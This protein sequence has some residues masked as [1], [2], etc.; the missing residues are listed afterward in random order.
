[1]KYLTSGIN[2]TIVNSTKSQKNYSLIFISDLAFYESMK[3]TKI[4]LDK[5]PGKYSEIKKFLRTTEITF[6]EFSRNPIFESIDAFSII[7]SYSKAIERLLHTQ[8]TIPF[9]EKIN[10]SYNGYIPPNIWNRSDRTLKNTFLA[11][12]TS[13]YRVITLG[14]W[15][16]LL[17][18]ENDPLFKKLIEFCDE[19]GLNTVISV[20]RSA[21][22]EV[23]E[24]D[25]NLTLDELRNPLS[26]FKS[27]DM[28]K[29][30]NIR[31]KLIEIVN[32]IIDALFDFESR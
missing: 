26:H 13:E 17:D 1:M 18:K 25:E 5:I 31:S 15:K 20:L 24:E 8:L 6:L 9:F 12:K 27:I 22:H 21:F 14:Q 11:Y 30:M 16:F 29:V 23:L 4:K 7:T 19:I 10:E 3:N 28:E 2:V 32:S